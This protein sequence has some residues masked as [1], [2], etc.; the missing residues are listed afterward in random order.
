[1]FPGTKTLQTP[2]AKLL[3]LPR[4]QAGNPISLISDAKNIYELTCTQ[5]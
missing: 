5:A 2:V 4:P 3:D 1:M